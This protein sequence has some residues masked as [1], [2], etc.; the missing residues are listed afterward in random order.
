MQTIGGQIEMREARN[1]SIVYILKFN[2]NATSTKQGN[3]E[4]LARPRSGRAA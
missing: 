3:A 2:T 1:G 4:A